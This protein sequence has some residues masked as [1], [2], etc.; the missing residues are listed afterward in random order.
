M[1]LKINVRKESEVPRPT[2][3]GK[4]NEELEALKE[5]M[6]ALPAGMVLELEAVGGRTVRGVKAMVTRA[7]RALGTSWRH[8]HAGNKVYARPTRRRRRR[9]AAAATTAGKKK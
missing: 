8:W 1:A 3:A 4:V 6:A 7:A 9:R 5:R 2:A